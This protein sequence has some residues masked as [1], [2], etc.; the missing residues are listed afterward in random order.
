MRRIV[1]CSALLAATLA[2][3][4][5]DQV[6]APSAPVANIE[7][8]QADLQR[9]GYRGPFGV[10]TVTRFVNGRQEATARNLL[11]P[12]EAHEPLRQALR[13]L[14]EGTRP[15]PELAALITEPTVPD[16][17]DPAHNSTQDRAQILTPPSIF[18]RI[19]QDIQ[20]RILSQFANRHPATGETYLVPGG[21][22]DSAIVQ[23][24]ANS[25][26]HYHGSSLEERRLDRRVGRLT[27]ESPD[28]AGNLVEHWFVPEVAQEVSLT[29]WMREV[30]GPRDGETNVFT[31]VRPYL[32]RVQGLTRIPLNPTMYTRLGG[33]T[34]HPEDFNDWATQE[35]VDSI[36]SAATAYKAATNTIM[37]VNDASLVYGGKFDIGRRDTVA[38]EVVLVECLD[39]AP[40][41]CWG[42]ISNAHSEHRLGTEV[43]INPE[44]GNTDPLKRTFRRIM[45]QHF[46]NVH[47]EGNH[48]HARVSGSIYLR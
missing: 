9:L 33:K 35:L 23:A 31:S 25:A 13:A 27:R 18:G 2:A 43:D 11:L 4:N 28:W 26:G 6:V 44:G 40:G 14:P 10:S 47:V 41:N 8:I 17:L 48:L 19:T 22:V 5:G 7:Q 1:F 45:R 32:V 20:L 36:T 21:H 39:G 38:G 16:S 37:R 15:S 46:S 42:S 12:P 24:R 3:C 30:G 29:Y 34:I